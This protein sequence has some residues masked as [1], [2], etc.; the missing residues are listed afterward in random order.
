M[1]NGYKWQGRIL[2]VRGDRGF[3]DNAIHHDTTTLD[4]SATATMSPKTDEKPL[5]DEKVDWIKFV[6]HMNSLFILYKNSWLHHHYQ[7]LLRLLR[8]SQLKF[9]MKMNSANSCLLEM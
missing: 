4:S 2:E 8:S 5:M 3:V 7:Q 1:F 9:Q 6:Y